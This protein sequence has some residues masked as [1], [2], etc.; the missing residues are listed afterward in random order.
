MSMYSPM[1]KMKTH[2]ILSVV[3][4][5]M[6]IHGCLSLNMLYWIQF[7]ILILQGEFVSCFMKWDF[8]WVNCEVW[9]DWSGG[10]LNVFNIVIKVIN[11]RGFINYSSV[12]SAWDMTW[13]LWAND[14]GKL[15][16]ISFFFLKM[17]RRRR[18]RC[19]LFS[20]RFCDHRTCL[21]LKGLSIMLLSRALSWFL[22]TLAFTGGM[23]MVFL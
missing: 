16:C 17:K 15:T 2:S 6:K 12:F 21:P 23:V 7:G 1:K 14:I 10:C 20:K 11:K 9:N 22:R 13:G 18:I 8:I 4:K 5:S 3:L 19:L